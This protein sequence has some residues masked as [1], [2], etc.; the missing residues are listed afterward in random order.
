MPIHVYCPCGRSLQAPDEAEGQQGVCP[1]CGSK[2]VLRRGPV[3]GFRVGFGPEAGRHVGPISLPFTIGRLPSCSMTTSANGVSREHC[4]LV[5]KGGRL[6]IQDLGSRN[7]TFVNGQRVSER[8][9]PGE[10]PIPVGADLRL[11]ATFRLIL[12]ISTGTPSS[13]PTSVPSGARS[14]GGHTADTEPEM[15]AYTEA[16]LE[17]PGRPAAAPVT[18][19]SV[20]VDA[21]GA[22][23]DDLPTIAEESPAPWQARQSSPA[24]QGEKE[25]PDCAEMVKERAK[26][27][28]FC[29]YSFVAVGEPVDESTPEPSPAKEEPGASRLTKRKSS[30]RG[31]TSSARNRA[32]KQILATGVDG[33]KA[34]C[35]SFFGFGLGT[36]RTCSAT[37]ANSSR[38]CL[39]C[40]GTGWTKEKLFWRLIFS[41][42][43]T[44]MALIGRVITDR[45]TKDLWE[46]VRDS[47]D[48][49]ST[50]PSSGEYSSSPAAA[51]KVIA[52]YE[53]A[54]VG[55]P[56]KAT[57]LDPPRVI[58]LRA[59][60]RLTFREGGRFE[61]WLRLAG[62]VGNSSPVTVL[63]SW[64][65][66]GGSIVLTYEESNEDSSKSDSLELIAD[67]TLRQDME[68][69]LGDHVTFTFSS[70]AS[71]AGS[72]EADTRPDPSAPRPSATASKTY[73]E[74]LTTLSTQDLFLLIQT[75]LIPR[76]EQQ[77]GPISLAATVVVP[78]M[79]GEFVGGLIE[80]N[81]SLEELRE[82]GGEEA[83]VALARQLRAANRQI[84]QTMAA[85]TLSLTPQRNYDEIAKPL[86]L[87]LRE[88]YG[89]YDGDPSRISL[90]RPKPGPHYVPIDA[91]S[92]S[93]T[94]PSPSPASDG[95]N[96]A[97]R[98]PAEL[99]EYER[100][101]RWLVRHQEG[102]GSWKSAGW[103]RHC[104]R[105]AGKCAGP[106]W[107]DGDPRYS[108]GVTG[109]ALLALTEAPESPASAVWKESAGLA[110]KWLLS[111]QDQNGSIG[112]QDNETA[113]NHAIATLALARRLKLDSQAA[114]RGSVERAIEYILRAQNTNLGWQ[115]GLKSGK[116]DTSVTGWMV[117]ALDAGK[118]AGIK[119][120][121][122]ALSGAHR[123]IKR[124]T[125]SNGDVGYAQPG[126]GSS[127]LPAQDGKFDP[128]P[129][130]T[131]VALRSRLLCGG[132]RQDRILRLGA[133]LLLKNLPTA[134]ERQVNYYY[135][136]HATFGLARYGGASWGRWRKPAQ[137]V[138]LARQ[139]KGQ[140]ADGSWPPDG[141]WCLAGG[142]VY[143]TAMNALTLSRLSPRR[144]RTKLNPTGSLT[145]SK[146]NGTFVHDRSG[147]VFVRVEPAA[148]VMG[149]KGSE[150]SSP[151]HRVR[152][153]KPFFI[154]K[155]E[156]TW[157]QFREFCTGTER[158]I[159]VANYAVSASHPVHQVN[160]HDAQAFCSWAGVRLPTEAEW[161][162]AARGTD[163][164]LYPWGSTAPKKLQ[165]NAAGRD[166]FKNSCMVSALPTGA[167]PT[168][169]EQMA[170]NLREWVADRYATYL[171]SE[172]VDPQGPTKGSKRVVRGGSWEDSPA[173]CRATARQ[174][175]NPFAWRGTVGFR[176]AVD[177]DR[178]KLR[179]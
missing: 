153:T 7:G 117:L 12:E 133:K 162:L 176:V 76:V 177:A 87:A 28:R 58:Q 172:Q 33:P 73:E 106:G 110:T 5:Y 125:A 128:V 146:R 102:D 113:Y 173:D 138:L 101:L 149:R 83:A 164:R 88:L 57:W 56:V 52:V 167:S 160:W 43:L 124:A 115:Y 38:L 51:G 75:E 17:P 4:R 55:K 95:T 40:A 159:P 25:C 3:L 14:A 15:P 94:T 61:R 165:V 36:C 148:F 119:V 69:A 137:R 163:G 121:K 140:C 78:E 99:R 8:Q 132:S 91:P 126:G 27:C 122:D 42:A 62:G 67:G 2:L 130:M 118:A 174:G 80:Q 96:L 145:L 100:A 127:V 22:Q 60:E 82:H 150:R 6:L 20:C 135:W 9:T 171:S 93:P 81:Q 54:W 155:Y 123:W 26:K 47:R 32:A 85:Q 50:E 90:S 77:R 161:E 111:R 107:D 109:L 30:R 31:K 166:P 139:H 79:W 64:R 144:E 39:Q 70:G 68:A 29:G 84:V 105:D 18:P 152:L 175:L 168:G 19:I 108:V 65:R 34:G 92:P 37:R 178:V 89:R 49:G 21:D 116:N 74:R 158:Q 103:N 72:R 53:A 120:P 45:A 63:G 23:D 46:R 11:G 170:G 41:A 129:S 112:V 147:L 154:G 71:L 44:V 13:H 104:Q 179:K 157:K 35:L 98:L 97:A 169:C 66:S 48:S 136:H 86:V 142:R 16:D 1:H 151:E 10:L 24:P 141:E 114:L 59:K 131:A 143:A 134:S 156:V